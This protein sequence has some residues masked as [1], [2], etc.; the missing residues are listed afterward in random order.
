[1]GSQDDMAEYK[2]LKKKMEEETKKKKQ[3]FYH[4]LS[5]SIAIS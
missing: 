3:K 2:K 5:P 4:P 1:V